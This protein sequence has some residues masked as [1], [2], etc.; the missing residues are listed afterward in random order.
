VCLSVSAYGVYWCGGMSAC[1]TV[2]LSVCLSVCAVRTVCGDD[3]F[4]CA[5][6]GR[7]I[8]AAYVCDGDNDCGDMSDEADCT[9]GSTPITPT[10]N[11][12][13]SS[14]LALPVLDDILA[15]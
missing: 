1:C 8:T 14:S 6:S 10:D 13:S 5:S 7:C 12:L 4:Q 3:E 2:C 9:S 11:G 15:K